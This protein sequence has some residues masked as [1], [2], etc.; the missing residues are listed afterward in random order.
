M[1]DI[2]RDNVDLTTVNMKFKF[3]SPLIQE[4][5]SKSESS[6]GNIHLIFP[7]EG[8]PDPRDLGDGRAWQWA[9]HPV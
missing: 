6:S 5:R 7:G 4:S 8:V 1:S 2:E 9:E 3:E